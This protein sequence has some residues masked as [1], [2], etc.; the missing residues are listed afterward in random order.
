MATGKLFAEN[1][2]LQYGR[3]LNGSRY[4]RSPRN[5]IAAGNRLE[6]RAVQQVRGR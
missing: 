6:E 1:A 5:F 4:L 2:N 3:K